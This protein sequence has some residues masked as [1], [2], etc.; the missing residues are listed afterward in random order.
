MR[1]AGTA[2]STR[3]WRQTHSACTRALTRRR[4]RPAERSPTSDRIS[5]ISS[6]VA[7]RLSSPTTTPRRYKPHID[8]TFIADDSRSTGRRTT[9]GFE[10]TIDIEGAAKSGGT[11]GDRPPRC[12]ELPS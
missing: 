8:A 12:H 1:A 11:V 6:A 3:R 4:T 10:V 2:R 9:K 7:G 5:A